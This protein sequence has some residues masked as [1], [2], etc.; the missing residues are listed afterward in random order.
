[1]GFCKMWKRCH[2]FKRLFALL[3]LFVPIFCILILLNP[4][5]P[6][7]APNPQIGVLTSK[8]SMEGETKLGK[9][10]LLMINML[11]DNLAFTAFVPSEKTFHHALK[12][13]SNSSL[14][15]D[16]MN[17]TFAILSRIMGF[18]TVPQHIPS[19][20][21]PVLKELN[22]H[23]VSGFRIYILKMSD[24]TLLA[25]NIR[26]EQVDLRKGEI[27]VHVME[28]VIMDADFEQSFISDYE[29]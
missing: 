18:C 13:Q 15:T 25:N 9:L 10:G 1:M 5:L 21:V 24:G 16:K 17:D 22:F 2:F 19:E 4:G 27:I 3:C 11:P 26:S 23:S 7:V 28:G 20:S 12:L 29:E 6:E 14:M 8:R